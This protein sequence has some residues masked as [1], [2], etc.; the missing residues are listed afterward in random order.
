MVAPYCSVAQW[1]FRKG[2]FASFA[3]YTTA[4]GSYPDED[5]LSEALQDATNI[6]NNPVHL[7]TPGANITDVN[8]L[9]ELEFT[10][11]KMTNRILD[12]NKSRSQEGGGFGMQMWSQAD[13]LM[14]HERTSLKL[15][16]KIKG[17]RLV[18]KI[19]F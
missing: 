14:S 10:C 11:Y 18:G 15:I 8:Y 1:A 2:G 17:K 3:D 7:N 9:E 12:I 16:S 13:Y 6:M 4:K 19:V 5:Q